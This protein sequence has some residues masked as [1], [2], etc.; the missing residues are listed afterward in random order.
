[1]RQKRHGSYSKKIKGIRVICPQCGNKNPK[2]ISEEDDLKRPLYYF[3]YGQKPL[4]QKIHKCHDCR[5]E[6]D[7][8]PEKFEKPKKYI[9]KLSV[10]LKK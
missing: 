8:F 2:H 6:W 10:K 5:H 1:M 9:K 4:Y 7:K 3:S